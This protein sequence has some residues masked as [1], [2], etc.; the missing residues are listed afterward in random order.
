MTT[1]EKLQ[2]QGI[3]SFAPSNSR[4]VI[5]FYK[6]LT[7]IVGHNGAGKTVMTTVLLFH[8]G[9][10]SL[11]FQTIIECLKYACT[12][13]FPPNATNGQAFVHDTKVPNFSWHF[14]ES[15]VI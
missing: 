2:I 13:E 1:I 7:I 15:S 12:G 8:F 4:N 3:R 14:D 6:P 9:F 5:E 10:F 11:A